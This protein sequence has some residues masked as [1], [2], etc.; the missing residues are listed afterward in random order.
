M[1]L[2]KKIIKMSGEG[3]YDEKLYTL[4]NTERYCKYPYKTLCL[5]ENMSVVNQVIWDWWKPRF[6]LNSR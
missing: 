2:Y 5:G 3:S 1:S 4:L 6:L